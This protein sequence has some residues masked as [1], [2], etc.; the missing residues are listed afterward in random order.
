VITGAS[1][2][3][4]R[5]CARLLA[6]QG[7][8]LV[9][10]SRSEQALRA[11]Q[12][13]CYRNGAGTVLIQPADV[14]EEAAVEAV[15]QLAQRRFGRVDA[16]VHTAAVVAYGRFEDVPAEAFRRVVDV[17]IHGTANVA[18]AA[19]PRFKEQGGGTLVLLESLLGEITTP[20]M[21]SYVT[22][23]WGVRG[24]VRILQIEQRGVPGVHVC[25]VSP[26]S[27]NTPVYLQAASYSGRQGK[28]PPPVV[29]AEAVARAVLASIERPRRY[30]SVGPVNRL[31]RFGFTA[32]PWLFD[33]LV[34]PLMRLG[35]LS[36]S[37]V[38]AHDGNVFRPQPE[39]E[40]EQ[41]RW[42]PAG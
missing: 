2:G 7:A 20:F 38:A 9:L 12:Q 28:P 6:A 3:I 29:P 13:E 18:R 40:A 41:G 15:A 26:G 11:V 8:D 4:G 42:P 1:S 37:P 19:L 24:L 34:T 23:K 27:V 16:W 30:R 21:G 25:A 14:L 17:G 32:T 33:R 31:A 5:A 36:R 22:S 39:G 35:G 10:S